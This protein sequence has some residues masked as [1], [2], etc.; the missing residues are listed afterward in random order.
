MILHLRTLDSEM[1]ERVKRARMRGSS[2]A[3]PLNA[4]DV[5]DLLECIA[6]EARFGKNLTLRRQLDRLHKKLKSTL[7]SAW[8]PAES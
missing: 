5:F 7:D 2:V 3:V 4:Y 6:A 1:K 8:L